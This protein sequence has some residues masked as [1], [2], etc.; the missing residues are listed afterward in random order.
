M[1]EYVTPE[2]EIVEFENNDI[3]TSSPCEGYVCDGYVCPDAYGT[4]CS[5][6]PYG[7]T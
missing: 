2:V 1:K 3:V 5:G 4:T 7:G 6:N